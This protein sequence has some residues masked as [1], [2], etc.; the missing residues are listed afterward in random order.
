MDDDFVDFSDIPD[1]APVIT[2]LYEKNGQFYNEETTEF[3]RVMRERKSSV[4]TQDDMNFSH[5]KAFAFPY[6]WD[7]Y[8]GERSTQCDPYGPLYFHPDDLIYYFYINRLK[9]L[10]VDPVDENAGYFQGFYGDL[11]GIGDLMDIKGRGTYTELYIFRLPIHNCYLPKDHD[12]SVITM[13]PKLTDS[14]IEQINYLATTY[15]KDNYRKLHK[16]E[17][18]SLKQM[19]YLYDQAISKT[20]YITSGKYGKKELEEIR[21]KMNREAVEKLKSL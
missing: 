18:P 10:W 2:N 19:K 11:V 21:N 1:N 13:G 20:P 12:L 8:T 6:Q 3:Y 15:Y 4:I 9:K 16:K 7:P 5:D 14:E 17:R